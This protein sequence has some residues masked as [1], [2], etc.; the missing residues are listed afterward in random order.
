[1]E[2]GVNLMVVSAAEPWHEVH[3]D[4]LVGYAMAVDV[5]AAVMPAAA[6]I[7]IGIARHFFMV[8]LRVR[9]DSGSRH[10]APARSS[11]V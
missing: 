3:A 10:G 1:L 7:T 4:V 8:S 6:S 2:T 5:K 9:S 11:Y